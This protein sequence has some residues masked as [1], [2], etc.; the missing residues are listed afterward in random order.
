TQL[1]VPAELVE[2]LRAVRFGE[3]RLAVHSGRDAP[4][5]WVINKLG[6]VERQIELDG[7]L[8]ADPVLL[9]AG[10][11]L[12]LPGRLAMI[13]RGSASVQDFPAPT[14]DDRPPAE[15]LH[16]AA[17]DETQLIALDNLGRLLR[18]QYR[19]APVRSLAPVT[20]RDLEQPAVAGFALHDGRLLIADVTGRLLVLDAVS[21]ETLETVALDAPASNRP[22]IA[23]GRL[24]VESGRSTL[25]CYEA[26]APLQELWSLDLEGSGLA[27]PPL[28]HDGQLLVARLDGTVLAVNPDSGEIE[29]RIEI[30]QTLAGGPQQ[31]GQTLIVPAVDGSLCPV[32]FEE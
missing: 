25:R 4:R 26:S 12:P 3:D 11:V 30:G 15:W 8:E 20:Q 28:A 6:Q 17:A 14:D 23:D 1:Q 10:I 21:L 13:G 32:E 31:I 16:V 19:A 27:G 2:P 9:E 22:W 7:P 24:Y 29:K 18:V 5:L